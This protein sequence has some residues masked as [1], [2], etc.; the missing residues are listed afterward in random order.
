M[1][2]ARITLIVVTVLGLIVCSAVNVSQILG[3]PVPRAFVIHVLAA[4]IVIYGL[5]LTQL[6]PFGYALQEPGGWRLVSEGAPT[7]AKLLARAAI[8][9]AIVNFFLAARTFTTEISMG[10]PGFERA[11]TGICLGFHA[12]ALEVTLAAHRRA[13]RGLAWGCANG[14]ALEA[15]HARCPACG[16]K[17]IAGEPSKEV[18]D[19]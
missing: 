4:S 18:H 14:H 7:W 11:F 6:I 16:A 15:L 8:A 2:L 5:A 19:G 9:Y 3:E 12:N 10:S 1:N 17:V 13:R